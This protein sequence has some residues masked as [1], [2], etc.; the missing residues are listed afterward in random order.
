MAAKDPFPLA[1]SPSSSHRHEAALPYEGDSVATS[2]PHG[3]A[4]ARQ[5]AGDGGADG[6]S[7]AGLTGTHEAAAALIEEVGW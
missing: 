6:G 5:A 3:A 2:R 4:R 7:V 1:K